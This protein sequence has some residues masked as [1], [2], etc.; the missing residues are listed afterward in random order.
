MAKT[1]EYWIEEMQKYP[2][3]TVVRFGGAIRFENPD[4]TD[5]QPIQEED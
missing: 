5:A 1:T 2:P 3:G 4:G